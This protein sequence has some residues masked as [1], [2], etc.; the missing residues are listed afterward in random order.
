MPSKHRRVGGEK[1]SVCHHIRAFYPAKIQ[2]RLY[3]FF[4]PQPYFSIIGNHIGSANINFGPCP[5]VENL[6]VNTPHGRL[7]VWWILVGLF[8]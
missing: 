3:K 5:L 6:G 4:G 8:P 1:T 7:F 2:I